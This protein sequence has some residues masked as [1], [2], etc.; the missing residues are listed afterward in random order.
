MIDSKIVNTFPLHEYL[1][2]L[3]YNNFNKAIRE[4]MSIVEAT[5][6]KEYMINYR[7]ELLEGGGITSEI[8]RKISMHRKEMRE[9][10]KMLSKLTKEKKK[11]DLIK[12]WPS[13]H[14]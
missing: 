14:H 9:L 7:D 12:F 2:K 8:G 3:I 10:N 1:D 5:V 6:R 13:I 4:G 11:S